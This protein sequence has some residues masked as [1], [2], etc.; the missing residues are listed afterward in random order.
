MPPSDVAPRSELETNLGIRAYMFKT[1]CLMKADAARVG[2]RDP[3][4][5]RMES[6]PPQDIEKVRIER[7][8]NAPALDR[9]C[10]VDGDIG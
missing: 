8:A 9:G 10:G 6:L 4:E 5:G 3:G 1:H 7:P 2:K